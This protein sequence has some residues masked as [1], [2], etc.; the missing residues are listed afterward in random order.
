MYHEV[1]KRKKNTKS[2]LLLG[3]LRKLRVFVMKLRE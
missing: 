3:E 2:H 1:T